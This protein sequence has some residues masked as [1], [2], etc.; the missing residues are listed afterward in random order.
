MLVVV[1]FHIKS[2]WI[3]G[4][5][6]CSLKTYFA[7]F[8][9]YYKRCFS[10]GLTH[11]ETELWWELQTYY[12]YDSLRHLY[13]PDSGIVQVPIF[14]YAF[15]TV[16]KKTTIQYVM[17]DTVHVVMEDQKTKKSEILHRQQQFVP[18]EMTC[19][20]RRGL[21]G[22]NF[23]YCGELSWIYGLWKH[24][25]S[26]L[27]AMDEKIGNARNITTTID[28]IQ[29]L[30]PPIAWYSPTFYNSARPLV[31]YILSPFFPTEPSTNFLNLTFS[32]PTNFTQR[33]QL[34]SVRPLSR[35]FQEIH[36]P[37]VTPSPASLPPVLLACKHVDPVLHDSVGGPR[38]S[39]RRPAPFDG[40]PERP[41]IGAMDAS[42][43]PVIHHPRYVRR[44]LPEEGTCAHAARR[45]GDKPR[46]GDGNV[47][48]AA[49]Y[50]PVAHAGHGDDGADA[51][52]GRRRGRRPPAAL[53]TWTG[54]WRRR[55]QQPG[56]CAWDNGDRGRWRVACDA[57][58]HCNR[59]HRAC[60][61]HH[62]GHE[63][64]CCVF[65]S[66]V[67]NHATDNTGKHIQRRNSEEWWQLL[68]GRRVN[69]L[70]S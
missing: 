44:P 7:K 46:A 62:H 54:V 14:C 60:A 10:M 61:H 47:R 32:E 66:R 28:T 56:V 2:I 6:N 12:L 30:T 70:K 52:A 37:S 63:T 64:P 25:Y 41:S 57:G 50:L 16:L 51:D 17:F 34:P 55:T 49:D 8:Y 40:K 19:N 29:Q 68:G 38:S 11:H 5:K 27:T 59:Y 18:M 22:C 65:R 1:R 26:K 43:R 4:W 15:L 21:I 67:W 45:D 31:P 48:A 42:A 39:V 53:H 69:S 23:R 58:H 3:V 20:Q 24:N 13:W 36:Q 9:T 35:H 33:H